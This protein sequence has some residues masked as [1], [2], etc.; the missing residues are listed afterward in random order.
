M[1][2]VCKKALSPSALPLTR[3]A[4]SSVAVVVSRARAAGGRARIARFKRGR[5]RRRRAQL[6]RGKGM[7]HIGRPKY[8]FAPAPAPFHLQNSLS[9]S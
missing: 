6:E 5:R 2:S 9:P 3:P 4:L 8:L 7:L 1:S